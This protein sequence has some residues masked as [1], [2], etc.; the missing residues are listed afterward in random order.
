MSFYFAARTFNIHTA[1][2]AVTISSA[3]CPPS[4]YNNNNHTATMAEEDDVTS[5][6]VCEFFAKCFLSLDPPESLAELSDGV[7]MFQALSEM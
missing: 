4:R 2:I 3:G 7:V 1:S 5:I 6:A